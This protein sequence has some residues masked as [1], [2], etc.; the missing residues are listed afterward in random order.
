MNILKN[1]S[2]QAV[3]VA[4]LVWSVISLTLVCYF[5][6]ENF[7]PKDKETVSVVNTNVLEL[8]E[9]QEITTS[10]L[11]MRL[12]IPS[13][14][15]DVAIE[16]VGVTPDG[17]MDIPKSADEVGWFEFGH[18]PGEK[19]TAVIAGHYGL[20]AGKPSVFTDLHNL[21]SDDKIYIED[22]KGASTSFVVRETRSYDPKA[23]ATD[24]F[25]SDDENSHLNLITCEGIWN[26]DVKSFSRRLVVFADKE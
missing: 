18:R 9:V 8:Q 16:Y 22:D 10:G 19:G 26:K 2:K 23:D 14:D 7:F 20:Y 6:F 11:P 13:I 12:K 17:A 21:K 25:S 4:V 15:I 1:F 5:N 24:V 3:I